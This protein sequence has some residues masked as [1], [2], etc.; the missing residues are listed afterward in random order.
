MAREAKRAADLFLPLGG[1]GQA[2]LE[3]RA[4]CAFN[5]HTLC[6]ETLRA[7]VASARMII[8]YP[9]KTLHKNLL[10]LMYVLLYNY[11]KG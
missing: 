9:L 3:A 8:F 1:L 5:F 4:A 7:F 10:H 2:F 6:S 11:S